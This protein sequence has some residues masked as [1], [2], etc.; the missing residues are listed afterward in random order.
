MFSAPASEHDLLGLTS[1]STNFF[2]HP[3]AKDAQKPELANDP[4][5]ERTAPSAG[6]QNA[7]VAQWLERSAYTR[8]VASSTLAACTTS[9]KVRGTHRKQ[10]MRDYRRRWI[11]ERRAAFFADKECDKC[12]SADRL[13]LHHRDPETKLSHKI[14]SWAESRRRAEI[15]KC[16]VLCNAC[17]K[18]ITRLDFSSRRIGYGP[19]GA[20]GALNV[21]WYPQAR[22]WRVEFFVM[23]KKMWIGGGG[24]RNHVT[25]RLA[26]ESFRATLATHYAKLRIEA[27]VSCRK[28]LSLPLPPTS[29]KG[30][31]SCPP[32]QMQ[33][34]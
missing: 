21:R 34:A 24:F 31:P 14:W 7:G 32:M 1:R 16:V 28:Q 8:E 5:L 9:R 13:E 4:G 30:D 27:V 2:G 10:Y 18:Y 11:Q 15:A 20:S 3:A 17:H 23:G 29:S 6:V 33:S 25:A 12:G 26:A 19:A 22:T